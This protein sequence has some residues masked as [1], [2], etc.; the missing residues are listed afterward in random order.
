MKVKCR[1]GIEFLDDLKML[2][3]EIADSG[4]FIG[5][6]MEIN[7]NKAPQSC[8]KILIKIWRPLQYF[9]RKI[10]NLKIKFLKIY[11]DFENLTFLHS[12]FSIK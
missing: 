2:G 1:Q 8:L 10:F 11:R 9:F 4:D 6:K 3:E 7:E 5:S 12:E